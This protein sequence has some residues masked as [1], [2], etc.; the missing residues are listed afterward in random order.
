GQHPLVAMRVTAHPLVQALCEA[1][2]GP[3]VSTSA[4]PAGEDPALSEEDIHTYFDDR[5]DFVLSG[6]LGGLGQPST[7]RNLLT[8]ETLRP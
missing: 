6:E 4:N 5:L 2:G 8:G 1:F 3:I 7:I